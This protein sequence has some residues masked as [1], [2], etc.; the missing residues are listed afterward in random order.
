MIGKEKNFMKKIYNELKKKLL[1]I[2]SRSK[3]EFILK[4]CIS[5]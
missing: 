3:A 1:N 5:N 4:N 2:S